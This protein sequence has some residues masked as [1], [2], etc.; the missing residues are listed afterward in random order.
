M[1]PRLIPSSTD[2]FSPAFGSIM[3]PTAAWASNNSKVVPRR[4]KLRRDASL[5]EILVP[6]SSNI[7]PATGSSP[8]NSQGR[9]C[10][11]KS[12]IWS[13]P[14][15]SWSPCCCVINPAS[16]SDVRFAIPP[17]PVENSTSFCRVTVLVS[18]IS[19]SRACSYFINFYARAESGI[20]KYH[21][22]MKANTRTHTH[23]RMRVKWWIVNSETPGV[24]TPC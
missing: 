13:S 9:S 18:V 23:V 6:L 14:V 10:T 8:Q 19:S 15:S 22:V 1:S 11:S 24:N 4:N 20:T 17:N 5:I 2:S 12:W 21:A 3:A 16:S 7:T